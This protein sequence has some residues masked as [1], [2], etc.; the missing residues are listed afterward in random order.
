M[1]RSIIRPALLSL[2]LAGFVSAQEEM[3]WV[4][5][6]D[7]VEFH[8]GANRNVPSRD[9]R[10]SARGYM[11]AAWWSPEQMKRNLVS[12]KTAAVPEKKPTTF[13]FIGATSVLPSEFSAGPSA[14]L[15]VNGKPALTFTLGL[16][17]DFVWKENGFQLKYASKRVEYPATNTHREFELFGNSGIYQLTVPASAVEAGQPVL[18]QVELQP[19]PAWTHGWFMVKERKDT[20]KDSMAT[21]KGE[22]ETLRQDLAVL[23]QQTHILAAKAYPE[24]SGTDRFQHTVIHTNGFRHLH[25]ADLIKLQNGELL[26]FTREGT[27]H[28][29]DDGDVI[30][31]RSKDG[32]LTWGD[33]KVVAGIVKSDE[34]EG[35]GIQLKDGT[36]VLGI[37]YN[38]LYKPDGTYNY[39]HQHLLNEKNR[40]G[41]YVIT[42]ND[43]GH[44]W[45]E[46]SYV[47]TTGMPFRNVEGPTD[48]PIEMPDGSILMAIIGYNFEGDEGNRSS[49]ILR[50]TDKG[51]TWSHHGTIASDKGNKLGG[52]M[53]PGI[54]RTKSGRIIAAMRNH[55]G[56]NAIWTAFSDDGGKTFSP[57]QKTAMIGHP[58][59]L[60]QLADGR[61]MATYGIRPSVHAKP[62]GIRACFSSDDGKTWDIG[63]EVQLRSD[64]LN[65]DVGYPESLQMP[66][67]RVLTVYY[68]NLFNKYFIGGT[69]WRP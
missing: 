3:Q 68:Y 16:N 43:N 19:F 25:P 12:W 13:S 33:R 11:T 27:E 21:L 26:L 65:W 31:L 17:R 9:F 51:R 39:S 52:F 53:E 28:I 59:D 18:L 7:K 36:I 55:A 32:G 22:I 23:Q 69:W 62:G 54:V 6:F 67:G 14:A 60:I 44:T 46:P 20:L 5:G 37:F 41:A 57:V 40:L 10:G 29:S 35:C 15:T 24:I 38:N 66:D 63:T 45:S 49:V 64:F 8:H 61:V 56:E 34:R 1:F 4:E 50:S 30:M 2:A 42:S 47:D 48:A 58:V